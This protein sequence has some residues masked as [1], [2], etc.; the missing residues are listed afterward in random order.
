MGGDRGSVEPA[1]PPGSQ[2]CGLASRPRRDSRGVG[3]DLWAAIAAQ[4]SQLDARVADLWAA[5]AAQ[6]SQLD[7]Q[8][9]DLWAGIEAQAA[10]VEELVRDLW[11]AVNKVWT[12]VSDARDVLDQGQVALKI[13]VDLMQRQ[14]FARHHEGIGDVRTELAEMSLQIGGVYRQVD[15]IYA[16]LEATSARYRRKAGRSCGRDTSASGERGR[17][18]RPD[19]ANPSRACVPGKRRGPTRHDGGVV[20]RLRRRL[21]WSPGLGDRG[22]QGLPP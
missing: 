14:A 2:I 6:S 22:R 1:R 18:A 7:L 15:D 12:A 17:L 20:P 9:A 10:H 11:A 8:V 13:H 21:P 19:S 4:S 16:K 5:I 3:R